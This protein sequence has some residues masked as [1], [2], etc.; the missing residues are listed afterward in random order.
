M[1]VLWMQ[2]CARAG[3]NSS[4]DILQSEFGPAAAGSGA[5]SHSH[6]Q[7]QVNPL[8]DLL[9]TCRN[10]R[11]GFHRDKWN[12]PLQTCCVLLVM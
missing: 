1:L 10:T 8:A 11:L 12:A 4:Q 3:C 2:A 9:C 5:G 7:Y 6:A